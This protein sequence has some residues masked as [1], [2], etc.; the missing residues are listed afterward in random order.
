[1]G[2]PVCSVAQSCLTLCD[3]IDCSLPDPSVHGIFQARILE[4][5]FLFQGSFRPNDRTHVSCFSCIGRSI[6]YHCTTW[7]APVGC[8]KSSK[9]CAKLPKSMTALTWVTFYQCWKSEKRSQSV[10]CSVVSDSLQP[11]GLAH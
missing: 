10:I 1:M 5:R 7:E 2:L 4:C 9:Y 3:L 8:L 6:L 11:H